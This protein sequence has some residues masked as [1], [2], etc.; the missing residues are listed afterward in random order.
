M[1]GIPGLDEELSAYQEGFWSVKLG[2]PMSNL[3]P[4]LFQKARIS[5]WE[6]RVKV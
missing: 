1:R 2:K 6:F 5:M 3:T 4:H